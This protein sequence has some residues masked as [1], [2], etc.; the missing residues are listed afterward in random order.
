MAVWFLQ[1]KSGRE[2]RKMNIYKAIKSKISA[3]VKDDVRRWFYY[4]EAGTDRDGGGEAG[5]SGNGEAQ[6]QNAWGMVIIEAVDQKES[7]RR[8]AE[9]ER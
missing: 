8:S 7:A 1:V 6:G 4:S 5:D 9:K 2:G 3:R